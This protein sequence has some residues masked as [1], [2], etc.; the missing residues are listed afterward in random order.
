PWMRRTRRRVIKPSR[1]IAQ[2]VG[3]ARISRD[4]LETPFHELVFRVPIV[5]DNQGTVRGDVVR[6]ARDGPF[7][8]RR[9]DPFANRRALPAVILD[10]E[11]DPRVP[12]A[13]IEVIDLVQKVVEKLVVRDEQVHFSLER[14]RGRLHIWRQSIE[15][16][17]R[18]H[19]DPDDHVVGFPPVDAFRQDP[20]NLAV[21]VDRVIRIL[22][23]REDAEMSE[24]LHDRHAHEKAEDPR[25]RLLRPE[26]HGKIE[27]AGR[28]G[29]GAALPAPPCRLAV[30]PEDESLFEVFLEQLLRGLVRRLDVV[31]VPHGAAH[32]L[33][34]RFVEFADLQH[35]T[36]ARAAISTFPA[37][38]AMCA[39]AGAFAFAR[40]WLA[41]NPQNMIA[42]PTNSPMYRAHEI[43]YR[44]RD[45]P[46]AMTK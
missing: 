2:A 29:P 32:E 5:H 31:I 19:T 12:V 25:V 36:D 21:L 14:R 23:P 10:Q 39:A 45:A 34:I 11:L 1:L 15:I 8:R 37:Q 46:P 35:R 20:G 4:N 6:P 3:R 38:E 33:P 42:I 30:R 9:D 44:A 13:R 26:D 43:P 18:V 40:S 28:R 17:V 22:Q 27:A 16:D 41:R 24:R 7:R